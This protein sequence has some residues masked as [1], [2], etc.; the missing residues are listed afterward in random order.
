KQCSVMLLDCDALAWDAE[1]IV[2]GL[3]GKYNYEELLQQLCILR[4]DE[5]NYGVP[6]RWNSLE[7]YDESTCLIH[8]TD[9]PTQPW[10]SPE[11]P[12]GWIWTNEVPRILAAGPLTYAELETERQLSLLRPSFLTELRLVNDSR[13]LAAIQVRDLA[14]ED[15]AAGFVK[16]AALIA[17]REQRKLEVKEYERQA[18]SG[19]VKA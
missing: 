10:V 5:V 2:R 4:E 18:K 9:M 16:H 7:H 11:N 14:K 12:L 1:E 15:A 6:F 8:Y 19:G 17:A 13:K 3:D